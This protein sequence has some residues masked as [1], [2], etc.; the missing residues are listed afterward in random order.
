MLLQRGPS[1]SSLALVFAEARLL[2]ALRLQVENAVMTHKVHNGVEQALA[3][4]AGPVTLS[5]VVD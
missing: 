4:P 1:S 2:D 5:V 3:S